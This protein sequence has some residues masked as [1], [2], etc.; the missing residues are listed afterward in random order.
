MRPLLHAG[1]NLGPLF[2]LW[3]SSMTPFKIS[4]A[5]VFLSFVCSP[6]IIHPPVLNVVCG[7]HPYFL[8]FFCLLGFVLF[9][10]RHSDSTSIHSSWSL[11]LL[12]PVPHFL[13]VLLLPLLPA[14][15]S[16]VFACLFPSLQFLSL[17]SLVVFLSLP[18][19]M[20]T[21]SYRFHLPVFFCFFPSPL[22]PCL[23]TQWIQRVFYLFST[24]ALPLSLI[25]HLHQLP[26]CSLS[27]SPLCFPSFFC[28]IVFMLT[29][30]SFFHPIF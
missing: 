13:S 6:V 25:P 17:P 9:P 14:P 18:A 27:L 5:V 12:F 24:M 7:F 26:S 15:V 4:Y 16:Q 21:S 3:A 11:T 23:S 8:F 22:I 1:T 2:N 29:F 30:S 19:P 20:T 28:S 10:P